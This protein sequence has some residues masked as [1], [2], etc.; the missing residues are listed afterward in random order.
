MEISQGF[1]SLLS[2]KMEELASLENLFRHRVEVAAQALRSCEI[3]KAMDPP[4]FRRSCA[5]QERA[6]SQAQ[7]DY[8]RYKSEMSRLANAFSTY[9]SSESRYVNSLNMV[10]TET[11]KELD[12][13]IQHL[14]EY[15]SS[16]N[17][18][19]SIDAIPKESKS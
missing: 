10:K 6:L 7:A 19:A 11:M 18:T 5:Y 4:E 1:T 15:A 2:R 3:A 17:E 8:A 16:A 14:S 12:R 9:K 13:I